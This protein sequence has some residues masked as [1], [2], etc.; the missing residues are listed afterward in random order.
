[1]MAASRHR[2][3]SS[4]LGVFISVIGLLLAGCETPNPRQ[5]N[6]PPSETD[7]VLL[8]PGTLCQR[9]T[10]FLQQHP[11]P[12][13]IAKA[14]GSGQELMV[15]GD[16]SAS[17]GDESYFFDEDGILVGTLFTFSSG[18][19]LEPYS[20]LR[21]TLTLLKPT[22]EF[23][24]TVAN[25]S[26]K[27]N[28]DSSSLYETGDEK[29]TTQYL[30]ISAREH[31]TLLQASVTIDPYVRLFSPYRR[32][33]LNRLRQPSGSQP[34]QQVDSQG[35]EDK[36]PFPSLQQFARGQ[37]AQLSYC[38]EQH[39]DIAADAYRKSIEGGLTNK[40]W[41]AEAHHKL[42]Q[43][44]FGL[45]QYEKAKAEMLQS[46]AIRPNT[47]EILNNLGSTQLK[48]GDKAGALASF[49]KA[50][51]LR[52]NYAIAR[53]N[54]AE[55]IEPTNPK[56]ALMEYETYLAL[57]EGNPEEADRIALVQQRVKK[58]RPQK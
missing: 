3:L 45:G 17:H 58:L 7:L 2:A 53:F 42:G 37:T 24:L 16:R 44:L 14:W 32:E 8:K 33:F 9:K 20:V 48:L 28:M 49:E 54:L 30:V 19:D 41:L 25:F 50:V 13:L 1:M 56:R 23:Y 10:A 55:A 26:G 38:G 34:G 31:P 46:L 21:H 11:Q 5:Q 18:L 4:S 47:P 6:L 43:S 22:L 51:S 15:P 52:P 29:T 39:Y 35:A 57:V 40:V 12:T 27:A 36:E